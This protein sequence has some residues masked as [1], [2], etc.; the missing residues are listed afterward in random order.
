VWRNRSP[1]WAINAIRI[2]DNLATILDNAI[3]VTGAI[4]GT[5]V[6]AADEVVYAP[7]IAV[8]GL[9]VEAIAGFMDDL[10]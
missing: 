8:T 2:S 6:W 7:E 10:H 1:Q 5:V 3:G 4:K 9:H